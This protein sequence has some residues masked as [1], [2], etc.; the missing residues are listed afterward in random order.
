LAS[1][2]RRDFQLI[3]INVGV[4]SAFAFGVAWSAHARVSSI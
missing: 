1:R 2:S 3:W 4:R